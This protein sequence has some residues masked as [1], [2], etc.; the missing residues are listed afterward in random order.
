MDVLKP[1]LIW[2][3]DRCYRFPDNSVWSTK[4]I[5]APYE[6]DYDQMEDDINQEVNN[7][8]CNIVIKTLKDGRFQH[9]A[10]IP[11]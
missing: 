8:D 11:Q 7:S 6:E 10:T 2:V 1:E 9:D 3:E 5:N 4:Q